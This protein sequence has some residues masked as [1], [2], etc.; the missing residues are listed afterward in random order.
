[1]SLTIPDKIRM[2]RE[3]LY[4]KAKDEPDFRFYQ[5]YDKVYREDI[6][7]YAWYV[8]R[9]NG[10][11]PGVDGV[12][13]ADIEAEGLEEWLK[14]LQKELHDKTYRPSAV[15]RVMIPKAGGGE[16]PLGI[17]T[18]R[19]RVAQTAVKLVI[20]PIFEADF[21]DSAHGYRP[22]RSALD[23]V[24]LTHESLREG[25]T[26]VVDA[27]LSKYFDNI[28]HDKLMWAVRQ[29]ITDVHLLKL[30]QMWLKV[31]V[32]ERDEKGKRR[33]TGGKRNDKGTPQG[34]VIS[35]LLANIYMNLYL[36]Q[37]RTKEKGR[38]YKARIVNYADDLV[39]LSKGRGADALEWTRRIMG[40]MG[41]S[42]NEDKTRIVNAAK[43]SFNF[44]GYTFGPRIYKAGGGRMKTAWPSDKSVQRI[45][46]KVGSIL[47]P[48]NMEPW[49]KVAETLNQ[50]LGGWKNYFSY[51]D[52]YKSYRAINNYVCHKVRFFLNRR[53]KKSKLDLNGLSHKVFGELGVTSM[54]RDSRRA[55]SVGR[56]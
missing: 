3:K 49:P 54:N 1:M 40:K 16:R 12:R 34:G 10:G 29:R 53:C 18:I 25:Y 35:P 50:T 21:E 28:P 22:G 43:E 14:G 11:A 38:E 55:A 15:R 47:K 31:P 26:D 27:D 46:D 24:R 56:S 51:G 23:A 41:L 8:S 42:L 30:I 5:L 36:K 17:P 39:I 37:W 9:A 7:R 45:K 19:D 20:E 48:G 32:E 2:F 6:L 52:T 4:D 13:F 44:L 33:I